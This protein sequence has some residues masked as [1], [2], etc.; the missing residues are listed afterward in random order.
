MSEIKKQHTFKL[1]SEMAAGHVPSTK[2]QSF[3]RKIS[4]HPGISQ[5]QPTVLPPPVSLETMGL[6]S[7]A[8]TSGRE[9]N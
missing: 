8:V 7:L 2:F 6:H 1:K 9:T 4:G 5:D 3:S